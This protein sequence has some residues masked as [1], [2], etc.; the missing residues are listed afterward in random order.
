MQQSGAFFG[1]SHY[2]ISSAPGC[3]YCLSNNLVNFPGLYFHMFCEP[4]YLASDD[5]WGERAYYFHRFLVNTSY[6]ANTVFSRLNAGL[7]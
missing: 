3:C 1:I 2:L 7:V 6:F 5:T 4:A